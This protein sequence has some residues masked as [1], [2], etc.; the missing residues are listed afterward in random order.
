MNKMN[1]SAPGPDKLSKKRNKSKKVCSKWQKACA[2]S[3][4]QESGKILRI[5]FIW[6]CAQKRKNNYIK[7]C[8][9]HETNVP[10]K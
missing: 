2:S 5:Q 7:S 1:I 8:L 6:D 3:E 10:S 4:V 9:L